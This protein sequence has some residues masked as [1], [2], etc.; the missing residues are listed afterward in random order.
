MTVCL[1]NSLCGIKH[2]PAPFHFDLSLQSVVDHCQHLPP[3]GADEY[4]S[5]LNAL[6]SVLTSHNATYIAEPGANSLYYANI[7]WSL[8]E[9]PLLLIVQPQDASEP[10]SVTNRARATSAR[11]RVTVLTPKFEATRTRLL[12]F[13]TTYD[14]DFV[15]WAEDANPYEIVASALV[16]APGTI[17]VDP[18][19]RYFIVVGLQTALPGAHVVAAPPE[20][21]ELRER[22]TRTEIEIMKCANEATVLAIRHV[23]SFMFAGMRESRASTMLSKALA[24]Y[25]LKHGHC[26]TLFGENA[27]LPYGSGTDR[28]LGWNHLALFDCGGVLH[29]YVSDV[30]RTVALPAARIPPE[31]LRVWELVHDA[32]SFALDAAREGAVARDVDAAAREYLTQAGYGEYFTHRLGHGIGLEGHESP[33][34]RG[35]SDSILKSGH[36]FSDEPGVYIE[37]NVGVRLED[38]FYINEDGAAVFLT[39]GVGGQSSSPWK[40]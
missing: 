9:R 27:A 25:G 39:E 5:R 38:C 29:G 22:K 31:H 14:V 18:A 37:G 19:I 15:E 34:L 20:V 6:S 13:P 35:G 24:A 26:L 8:S 21:L 4:T 10:D 12:P 7:S 11:P 1:G 3:I 30:T 2:Y 17:Y 33:Y 23:H 40:P 28:R 36:T 16:L 32:Q